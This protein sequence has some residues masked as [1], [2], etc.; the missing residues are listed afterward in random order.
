MS[1]LIKELSS[2]SSQMPAKLQVRH[3]LHSCTFS[4]PNVL[5]MINLHA[6]EEKENIHTN[7]EDNAI[8]KKKLHFLTLRCNNKDLYLKTPESY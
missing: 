5:S 6:Q 2:Y 8:Q 3:L 7:I 4:V 1:K